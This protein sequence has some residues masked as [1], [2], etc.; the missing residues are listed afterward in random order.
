MSDLLDKIQA[1]ATRAR[2]LEQQLAQ[3]EVA[4]RM[5]ASSFS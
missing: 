1:F 4:S 3:P 5:P 2:K